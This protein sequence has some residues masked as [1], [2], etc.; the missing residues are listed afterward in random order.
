MP[1]KPRR[2]QAPTAT[3]APVRPTAPGGMGR[4]PF[5]AVLAL[6]ATVGIAAF[7]LIVAVAVLAIHPSPV[8]G[9]APLTQRQ[10]AE[11]ALYAIGFFVVLPIVLVFVPRLADAIGA[12]PNREG[13][14][15]LAASL[16]G[17]LAVAVLVAR[18]LP[19]A[20]GADA[21]ATLGVWSCAAMAALARA[22]S[23]RPWAALDAAGPFEGAAWW[24][25]GGLVA[26][27]LLAFT[28]LGSISLLSLG[29]AAGVG[30]LVAWAARRGWASRLPRPRRW[31]VAIDVV[32]V[33]L[34]LFVVPDLVIFEPGAG[35]IT[36]Y[37]A[38]II[39]FHQDFLL[40]PA[41]QLLAGDAVLVK[42]ASQY[43]VLPIY[44]LA[45]W[46][47]LVPIGYG[48]TGF[49]DG[50]LYVLTFA[51][52]YAILRLC[53]VSR[54][55]A[56]SAM[57]LAVVVL[58][59]NL[60]YPVGGLL[61]HGPLRFGIP[62]GV[63]L[64]ATMEARGGRLRGLGVLVQVVL[65]GIAAIWA[66]EAFA[67]TLFTWGALLAIQAWLRLP[68]ERRAWLWRRVAL[69]IG[70]CVAAHL[71]LALATL[72]FA[73][74]LP[75][76]GQYFE[77]LHVLL[78]GKL[79]DITYDYSRWSPGLPVGFAYGLS[80]AAVVL[81][82]RRRPDIVSRE[83]VAFVGLA[84]ITAYGIA[85]YTYFVNRSPNDILPYVSF[86]LVLAATLWLAVLLRG[87]P[88]GRR[89]ARAGVWAAALA[90]ALLV[91]AVAW[92]SIGLRFS[93][94][95]LAYAAPGGDSLGQAFDRLW[96]PPPIEPRAPIGERLVDQ[97]MPGQR[98][99][100]VIVTPELQ[101]EILIRSGRANSLPFDDAVE[102]LFADTPS[103]STMQ[104]AVADLGPGDRVLVQ[105][106]GL[107][108]AS[109]LRADPSR[110]AL[111]RPVPT[112]AS[113]SLTP[114]QEWILGRIAERFDLQV[115]AR[116]GQ[117]LAVVSLKPRRSG[118]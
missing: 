34:L 6:T 15:L 110:D 47:Q 66:L 64:G 74:E 67:Y 100:P 97:Y 113:D 86:P 116:D 53:G 111:T 54:L 18:A 105:P 39:Q 7:S 99:V 103:T 65:V 24:V 9:L 70:A 14:P 30:A 32:V 43:G 91:L 77:F 56:T 79:A 38:S 62:M 94:T 5:G 37:E 4:A 59:Y 87:A 118:G 88:V 29:I 28:S 12:G 58:L 104:T 22:R 13:L 96:H 109:V 27:S 45:G 69:G 93:H 36:G 73:G 76:W 107:R 81:A 46:F 11:S 35:G 16:A 108:V 10:S 57:A 20:S 98:R 33:V 21:L 114:Q 19:W 112:A 78:V 23:S 40:G 3:P 80:A 75:H 48:T 25:A 92:S 17:G 84:G 49:L 102:D 101:T 63:V 82:V 61:Q 90:P 60:L 117:G 85:L 89:S 42:T 8:P 1:I 41:N 31:G 50:L 115:L 83:P 72:A 2:T 68:G 71:V 55:L 52:G 26:V 51:S 44:A 95:A 106:T